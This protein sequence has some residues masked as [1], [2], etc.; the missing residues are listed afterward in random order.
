MNRHLASS[1]IDEEQ[2]S[3]LTCQHKSSTSKA[4]G[5]GKRNTLCVPGKLNASV[6]EGCSSM[7]L[8]HL[9]DY[10]G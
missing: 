4:V 1:A 5:S 9:K 3:L 2:S 7:R 6:E 8:A 10:I